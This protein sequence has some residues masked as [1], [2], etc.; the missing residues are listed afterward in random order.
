[1]SNEKTISKILNIVDYYINNHRYDVDS[2]WKSSTIDGSIKNSCIGFEV[3]SKE[4][5]KII[6]EL[7]R[8]E[9]QFR[10]IVV[11]RYAHQ[12]DYLSSNEI[13]RKFILDAIERIINDSDISV[14]ERIDKENRAINVN[15]IIDGPKS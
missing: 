3:N 9:N 4:G 11:D 5:Y 1:M 6:C 7:L 15:K 2:N 12:E 13:F 14:L 10:I 8:T